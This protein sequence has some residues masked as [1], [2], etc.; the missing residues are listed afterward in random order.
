MDSYFESNIFGETVASSLVA[1]L[2]V[3]IGISLNISDNSAFE[4]LYDNCRR[5]FEYFGKIL[6]IY[7]SSLLNN[8]KKR[9]MREMEY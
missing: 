3:G 2:V 7:V 5:Q 9:A 6:D 1:E 4:K 8:I